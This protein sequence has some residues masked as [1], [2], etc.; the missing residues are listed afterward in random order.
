MKYTHENDENDKKYNFFVVNTPYHN[1]IRL[2]LSRILQE[3]NGLH[4]KTVIY[5]WDFPLLVCCCLSKIL[6]SFMYDTERFLDCQV[7]IF[8]VDN[9]L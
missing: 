5:F 3:C 7:C 2:T 8:C 1:R 6:Y 4:H 9:R